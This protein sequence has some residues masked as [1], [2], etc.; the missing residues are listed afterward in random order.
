M[1][2][3]RTLPIWQAPDTTLREIKLL[4]RE[5]SQY[6]KK[7]TAAIN[8]LH[9]YKNGFDVP[10]IIIERLEQEIESLLDTIVIIEQQ[11]SVLVE[12]EKDIKQTIDRITKVPGLGVIS[13]LTVLAET[14]NFSLVNNIKQLVSYAGLDVQLNQS[15][16]SSKRAR[17][18]KKGHRGN[19]NSHIRKALYMPALAAC[20]SKN[21]SLHDF[22]EGVIEKK[23][24][25]KIGVIA[26]ERKLL[27]LIY[28]LWKSKEEFDVKRHQSQKEISCTIQKNKS[29]L[30]LT[31]N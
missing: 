25:K 4:T 19:G 5:R 22:Y 16:K 26:V 18:S 1:G 21:S 14:N 29:E 24:C 7:K 3:E 30:V 12:Q 23:P 13:V 6:Q 2:L 9:A 31:L 20:N 8:Q 17:I 28:S 15:G 11:L 10:K 27:I